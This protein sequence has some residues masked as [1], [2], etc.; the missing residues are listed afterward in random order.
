[1]ELQ[2]RDNIRKEREESEIKKHGITIPELRLVKDL[3][4][5]DQRDVTFTRI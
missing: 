4:S 2:L 1:M 3:K 5:S